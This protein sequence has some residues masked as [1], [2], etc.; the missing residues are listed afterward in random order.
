M[1]LARVLWLQTWQQSGL[2]SSKNCIAK[3]DVLARALG[4]A[5]GVGLGRGSGLVVLVG[6]LD[7][8]S[9]AAVL[10]G[11][12]TDGLQ[13]GQLHAHGRAE[14][15]QSYLVGNLA[16]VLAAVDVPQVQR[17]AGELDAVGPLDEGGA[18]ALGHRPGKV[19]GDC[20]GHCVRCVVS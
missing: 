7:E 18:V 17:V 3:T 14:Q 2:Q 4:G 13:R 11:N 8:E 15:I 1:L 16:L 12:D 6:L 10:R 19:V 5:E 9:D 20:G